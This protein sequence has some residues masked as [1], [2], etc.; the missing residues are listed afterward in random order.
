V[1]TEL[2]WDANKPAKLQFFAWQVGSGGLFIGSRAIHL[3][4]MGECKR[5]C[6]GLIETIEHCMSLYSHARKVWRWAQNSVFYFNY[7]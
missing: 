7:F 6:S 4:F 1:A 3:G 2:I 5:C